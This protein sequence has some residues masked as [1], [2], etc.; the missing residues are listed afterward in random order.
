[1]TTTESQLERSPTTRTLALKEWSAVAHALLDGRQ[2]V[3][4]RKGGI[5]EKSFSVLA[6]E[7]SDRFVLYPTVA[8]AHAE[9]V[10]SVHTDLLQP[11]QADVDEESF[12]VR[13]GLTLVDVVEVAHLDGL[14]AIADLHIWTEASVHEDRVA[15]RPKYA[16]QALIVRAVALPEPIR[17]PRLEAYGGCRS[18][19]ELPVSWDGRQGRQVHD[20]ARLRADAERVRTAVG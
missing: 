17:L 20:E 16:L 12:V 11:G 19:L 8:H 4:L 10:R 7:G 5:H 1:M 14:P 3:L 13:C 2:T 18:W 6:A 9:R 15:F